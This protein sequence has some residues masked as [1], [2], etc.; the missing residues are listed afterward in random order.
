LDSEDHALAGREA[1]Q[2]ARVDQ[3]YAQLD[4]LQERHRAQGGGRI[5][6]L[7]RDIAQAGRE[8]A[9]RLGNRNAAERLCRNLDWTPPDSPESLAGLT[10]RARDVVER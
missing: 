6:Q 5:E 9:R 3:D 8:R 1:A 10:D 4:R 7:E 2:Q